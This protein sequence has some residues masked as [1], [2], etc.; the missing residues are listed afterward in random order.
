MVGVMSTIFPVYPVSSF[1]SRNAAVSGVSSP[2]MRP[3]GNSTQVACTGGRYCRMMS[4][5]GGLEGWRRIGAIAT[6]SMPPD[7]R[8]LRFAASQ[9]LALPS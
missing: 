6:A 4:V 8:V 9:T 2:S 1:N 3:A 5:E 7:P